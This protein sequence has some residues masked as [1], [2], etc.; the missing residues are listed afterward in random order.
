MSPNHTSPAKQWWK[1]TG[2]LHSLGAGFIVISGIGAIGK[3]RKRL[4]R[5]QGFTAAVKMLFHGSAKREN[6]EMKT[7]PACH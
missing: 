7:V 5:F 3:A 2:T 4:L 6:K 1:A